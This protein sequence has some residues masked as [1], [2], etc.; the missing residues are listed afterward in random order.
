MSTVCT[1]AYDHQY[2]E[3]VLE[4][5]REAEKVEGRYPFRNSEWKNQ[6]IEHM[7][8]H[9]V[10]GELLRST[11]LSGGFVCMSHEAYKESLRTK[12]SD[13]DKGCIL[14][15]AEVAHN[16]EGIRLFFELDY[17]T[18]KA[19]LPT[20][21]EALLHLRV[22]YR[23]VQE[24][25]PEVQPLTMHVATCTRKRKQRRSPAGIEL[26]WGVHVVFPSIV[27][28]TPA[29]K[30]IAQLLDTRISNLFPTWSNIV[31]PA[32]YRSSN[33]TLRPC[34][35][36]KMVD[37]PICTV[38]TKTQIKTIVTGKRR[39][40]SDTDTLFRLQL[41]EACTCFGGRRVDSSVYRYTGTL[42]AAAGPVVQALVGTYAVLLDM[43]IIP[44]SMGPLTTGF[45]RPEDM[46]DEQDGIPQSAS[47]FSSERRVLTGLSRRKNM[48]YVEASRFPSG[49]GA[50]LETIKNIH[51]SYKYLAIHRLS[52]DEKQRMFFITVKGSGSRYCMYRNGFHSSNRVYFCLNLKRGR[53]H[54]HCFDP[55]CK[56]DHA[57]TPVIRSLSMIDRLRISTGFEL[58][59]TIDRPTISPVV[60]GSDDKPASRATTLESKQSVWE[61]KRLAYSQS[62]LNTQ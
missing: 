56:R 62:I 10:C 4:E 44:A 26:A 24:C 33:A 53:L 13:I 57:S 21:D 5:A 14:T 47:L 36:Y 60:S 30:L 3:V 59:D 49:Y 11:F 20:W 43:S 51:E 22:L 12:T 58:P 55:D 9:D 31:D 48:V 41:S 29:M 27:T 17:R 19:P 39:Q 32:S 16:C 40:P 61:S 8:V 25:Y 7:N 35:S 15:D 23:T 54:M 42:T 2:N 46:G 45:C 34:F 38:G 52:M 6:F 50:L 18:S 37:C 1:A 28:K